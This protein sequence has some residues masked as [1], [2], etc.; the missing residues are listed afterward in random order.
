MIYTAFLA[1]GYR[2]IIGEKG[3][4]TYERGNK[5]MR[6]LFGAFI[7]YFKFQV[8]T[9]VDG[10]NYK[11]QVIKGSSGMSGGLIG[12]E[13]VKKELTRLSLLMQGI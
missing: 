13:Q 7:K 2:L 3:N 5:T 10:P 6:I 11:V 8:L 1:S 9:Y 4:G 12:I